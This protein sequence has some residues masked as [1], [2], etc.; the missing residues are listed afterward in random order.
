M[1]QLSDDC[2]AF[3]GEL[4]KA[5]EAIRILAERVAPVAT[6]ENVPLTAARGRTLAEDLVAPRD[7]PPHDNAAVDGYAVF[8]D[9]LAAE[10]ETRLRVAGRI[11]A[12]QALEETVE[13]G[14]AVRIFTGAP[15]PP[16]PDTLFMQEDV[17]VD[18]SEI[19]LPP[20]IKRG[21]NRRKAGEDVK[22]GSV[23]LR[24]GQRLRPQDIGLAASVGAAKLSLYNILKVGI[25]S[26]GD[27]LREPGEQT[28]PGAV[29][30]AN[31]YVLRALLDQLGCEVK[32]FGIVPDRRDQIRQ[33][34][35][36]AAVTCDAI[37]TSGGMSTGDED[38]VRAAVESLGSIHFW[39][40]AIRPGRPVALGH[41]KGS[42]FVGLPGNPVAMM[43]TFLRFARPVLLRLGGTTDIEP[44]TFR[45]R[46]D[47]DTRK[48]E[49]RREWL[50]ARLLP[51]PDGMPV[52]RRFPR[53]GAGILTSL[54]ES[55]GLI[56]LPEE[57]TQVASGTMVDFLPF[58]E[59]GV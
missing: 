3:G 26:T 50:R 43:V 59:V 41:V 10:G 12:G 48:K 1:A 57:V 44:K 8:F 53:D 45:V 23:I 33:T 17:R 20:G 11:A 32:D 34:L 9:D 21:A 2:F 38:H 22:A 4:M 55:D 13:R 30:D 31:R 36:N 37:I 58:S 19:V 5:A 28:P 18:G 42:P 46:A 35:A 27:E 52:A 51:G 6:P 47:F 49:G 7:V 54:V 39:R 15:M 40:L 16:G 25:F 24:K 29:Y 56:E 14:T